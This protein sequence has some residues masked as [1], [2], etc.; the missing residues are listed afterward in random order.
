[1]RFVC[2]CVCVCVCVCVCGRTLISSVIDAPF[3]GKQE[4]VTSDEIER[5]TFDLTFRFALLLRP[6]VCSRGQM[7]ANAR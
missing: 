6:D 7:S 3:L 5:Q 2:M 1:M 4:N